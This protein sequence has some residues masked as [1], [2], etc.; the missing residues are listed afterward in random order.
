[1]TDKLT[2]TTPGIRMARETAEAPE[3]V[4]RLLAANKA[5]CEDLAAR[6]NGLQPPV[7]VTCARGSSDHAATFGKYLLETS[8]G[9]PVSSFAPSV[10][11]V[12]NVKPK[13]KGAL[14]LAISQSG[15]SPDLLKSTEA[16]RDA[17]ATVVAL[18]N[19]ETSPLADLADVCLGLQAGAETSVAATKSFIA[20]LA[21]LLQMTACWSA[22]RKLADALDSLPDQLALAADLDWSEAVNTFSESHSMFT[23]GRGP[24]FGIALEAALKFKETSV[25]HA[26]AFSSAEL[27][28]GPMA[29]LRLGFPILMFSQNDGT[30]PGNDELATTLRE[31]GADLFV[32]RAGEAAAG[33]L[34][35]PANLHPA[36]EPLA[37]IQSFYRLAGDI[38]AARG[39]DPDSPRHLKKVTETI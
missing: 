5:A 22:D 35:V 20:S 31:K 16:A 26:E 38:A 15:Q 6:L 13:L 39:L 10:S 32:A 1:M 30:L 36:V 12:Y 18:V 17:G 34:P 2:T 4:A 8:L 14:F 24:G 37:M 33:R 21:G 29:L 19:D 27:A 11:S 3:A 28:H 25:L 9:I 7:I 23:L